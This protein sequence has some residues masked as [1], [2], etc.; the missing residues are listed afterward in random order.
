[1]LYRLHSAEEEDILLLVCLKR[2]ALIIQYLLHLELKIWGTHKK[3]KKH[4]WSWMTVISQDESYFTCCTKKKAHTAHG[5][6]E[7]L[8]SRVLKI[9]RSWALKPR[10]REK[11]GCAS[12]QMKQN[13]IRFEHFCFCLI[14]YIW[15][16][17]K[18]QSFFRYSVFF[19]TSEYRLCV[20]QKI[21]G[22]QVRG[23]RI[24]HY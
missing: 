22:L 11:C 12:P 21:I 13:C 15:Q 23:V 20:S 6:M 4:S 5:L 1:M 7:W 24:N 3:K 18:E 9:W 2:A 17:F 14:Y 16:H 19:P 10:M 8:P